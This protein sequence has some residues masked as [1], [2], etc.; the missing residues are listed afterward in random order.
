MT[1]IFKKYNQ[2]YVLKALIYSLYQVLI[3]AFYNDIAELL[4]L[5]VMNKLLGFVL[6]SIILFAVTEITYYPIAYAIFMRNK[7][8]GNGAS[9][10]NGAP[11]S[12]IP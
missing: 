11:P 1:K 7:R 9:I 5:D 4:F 2:G 10:E 8:N 12:A 6:L 3:L